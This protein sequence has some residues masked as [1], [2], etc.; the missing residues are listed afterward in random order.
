MSDIQ[1]YLYL[2]TNC[3]NEYIE[4]CQNNRIPRSLWPKRRKCSWEVRWYGSEGIRYSKSFKSRKE[5]NQYAIQRQRKVDKGK[6]DRPK[7]TTLVQF[8]NEHKRVME[9]RIA[10][11]TLKHQ[12]RMLNMLAKHVGSNCALSRI[13][14]RDAESFIAS[15]VKLGRAVATVN[16]DL[17]TLKGVF[18]LAIEP[19]GYL[20]EGCNPFASIRPRKF[21]SK[22]P[23]YVPLENFQRMFSKTPTLWWK[24]LLA[25]AYTSGGRRDELL[26]L[27]WS[28]IDFETQTVR[29]VPKRSSEMI[30]AWEPKDHQIREV[31]IPSETL[32]LLVNL[33]LETEETSPYVFISKSRL[34]HILERR[35]QGNW[36]P[37]SDIINNLIRDLK[38]MCRQAAVNPFT[39]H[40]LRRSCITNWSKKL[41]IQAVQHLAGHSSMETTR[42]YYLSV[43]E[44]DLNIARQVQSQVMTSLTNFLTNSG[45]NG[46]F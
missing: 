19:R 3:V 29:F 9:G 15:R 8:I 24:T 37:D 23:N 18:N 45:Q 12:V 39:F 30:L 36:E 46:Q 11:T 20:E 27:T 41:P 16:K 34:L 1:K 32:Q 10:H 4:L 42:R 14:P 38:V 28:D 25:L 33:Q 35:S 22:P 43:Q 2:T 26:N 40:D 13:S 5:A 6:R 7:K 17:R 31:P 21:T 44:S